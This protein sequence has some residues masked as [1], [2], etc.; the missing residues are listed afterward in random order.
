[1]IIKPEHP[2][3][4][5]EFLKSNPLILYGIGQTGKIITEWCDKKGIAYLISDKCAERMVEHGANN[6]VLPQNIV[7]DYPTANV[8][9]SSILYRKE[10]TKDL[11]DL[12][13]KEEQIFQPF[14]FMPDEVDYKDIEHDKQTDWE[15]MRK[16]FK[17]ISEWGWIPQNIKSV[18]DYGAGRK[19]IKEFLPDS[20]L[21]YPIDYINRGEDT[22]LCDFNTGIFPNINT[23]LS[24]CTGVLMYVE[25]AREL[26]VHMCRHTER[27]IIFSFVALD[28][29]PDIDARKRY[30]M[31]NHFTDQQII[32]IFAGEGFDLK[33]KKG[34][35]AGNSV[36]TFYLFDR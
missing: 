4:L 22:I 5:V 21:Y 15:L 24:V 19:F 35:V 9:I 31:C 1:M 20:V 7:Y 17:V 30:G 13:I 12:G 2:E 34:D 28:S 6:V 16:R 11:L 29:M 27:R 36:M 25:P 26:I 14:I 8:V 18:V 10:I 23:E 33:D 32:D 3:K